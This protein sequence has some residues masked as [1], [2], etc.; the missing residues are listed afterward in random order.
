MVKIIT[1]ETY[2]SLQ[3]KS[4]QNFKLLRFLVIFTMIF[5]KIT[6]RYRRFKE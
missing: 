3:G 2:K 1:V 6:Y 5:Q 4:L